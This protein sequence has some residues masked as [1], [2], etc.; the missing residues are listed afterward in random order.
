MHAM[1][2]YRLLFACTST[3]TITASSDTTLCVYI[4][5]LHIHYYSYYWLTW[6]YSYGRIQFQ[7]VEIQRSPL[8]YMQCIQIRRD[9]DGRWDYVRIDIGAL[10]ING[11]LA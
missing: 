3:N 6:L 2:V 11:Q 9:V 10:V 8:T 1:R 5:S 4:Y 7:V